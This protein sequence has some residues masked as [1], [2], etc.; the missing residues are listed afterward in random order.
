MTLLTVTATQLLEIIEHGVAA[1]EPGATPGQFPQV[2]GIKF[3]FDPDLPSGNRVQ[4]LTIVDESGAIIDTVVQNSELVGDASRSFRLVTLSF[5]ADGGD[6]YPFPT[7]PAADRVDLALADNAPRT[8]VATFA[9]DGSEQDALAEYLTATFPQNTPVNI[10]DTSPQQD[11]R[12]QNL[13]ARQDT[14]LPTP[15]A[16][17]E[18]VFGTQNNDRLDAGATPP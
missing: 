9:P 16:P 8:G 15:P 14:V 4:S 3:S 7:T 12:I 5:L 2:S 6:G 11:E 1:T 10:A 18:L 17:P 13:N